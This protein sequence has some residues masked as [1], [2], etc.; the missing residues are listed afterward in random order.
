MGFTMEEFDDMI[1]EVLAQDI[2]TL[3][4][5]DA[6]EN[7]QLAKSMLETLKFYAHSDE[8]A[9]FYASICHYLY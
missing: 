9:E 2:R 1:V 4:Q 8:F 3:L 7:K 5:S 6:P